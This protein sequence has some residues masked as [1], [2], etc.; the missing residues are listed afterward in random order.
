[1]FLYVSIKGTLFLFIF[2]FS[3]KVLITG[4]QTAPRTAGRG[5]KSPPSIV[6]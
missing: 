4:K 6:L 1:M 5:K 3:S 2:F